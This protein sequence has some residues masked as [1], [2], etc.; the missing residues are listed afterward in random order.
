MSYVGRTPVQ[1]FFNFFSR[2][3]GEQ[4]KK[5]AVDINK[6]VAKTPDI[7]ADLGNKEGKETKEVS[8][9]TLEDIG[10]LP[11]PAPSVPVVA[12]L[13]DPIPSVPVIQAIPVV[14]EQEKL[15]AAAVTEDNGKAINGGAEA[16]ELADLLDGL[17]KEVASMIAKQLRNGTTTVEKVRKIAQRNGWM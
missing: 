10:A 6:S 16:S 14:V 12:G 7:G 11:S 17:E 5:P 2:E 13:G 15:V 4:E 8:K 9:T 3:E 1:V